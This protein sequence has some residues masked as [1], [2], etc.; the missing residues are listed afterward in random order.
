MRKPTAAVS[1]QAASGRNPP[2]GKTTA[3]KKKP[4]KKIAGRNPP[5][6]KPKN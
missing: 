2:T 5:T 1:P 6:G 4:A 3:A